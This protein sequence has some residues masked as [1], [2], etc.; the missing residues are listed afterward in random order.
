[1]T[2]FNSVQKARSMI[3]TMSRRGQVVAPTIF[4]PP[5]GGATYYG[6]AYN[7]EQ[8]LHYKD[9]QF[10]AIQAWIREIAGGE[11]LN[12]GRVRKRKDYQTGKAYEVRKAL[13]QKAL[14]GPRASHEFVP[15]DDDDPM[16]CLF[17]RPNE[18]DTPY[19]HWAYTVLFYCLTGAAHWWVMRNA[20]QM[21]VEMWVIP[22]H[23]MKLI[24]RWGG[25][26]L[27]YLVQ[28]PWGASL[29]IPIDEVL[30]FYAHS[31]LNRYEG[32]SQQLA[33]AEWVDAYEASV[34]ARLAQFKNGAI[35][36]FHIALGDT[37]GDPDEAFL[38]RYYSKW[39]ARFQ[40][41]DRTNMPVITGP[42]VEI[43]AL[44][45]NPVDMAYEANESTGRDQTLA[46]YGVPKAIPGMEPP[47]DTSGYAPQRAFT[48]FT[49]NPVC[50]M[51]GERITQFLIRPTPGYEDG[52]GYWDD[53]ILDDPERKLSELT[54]QYDR[55]IITANEFRAAMGHPPY[56]FGGDDPM[57]NG[58]PVNWATGK[59]PAQPQGAEAE[60]TDGA[61]LEGQVRQ[62]LRRDGDELPVVDK[63]EDNEPSPAPL[64]TTEYRYD[65]V[66]NAEGD[67]YA[68]IYAFPSGRQVWRTPPYT[69]ERGPSLAEAH[70]QRWIARRRHLLESKNMDA[71]SGTSGGYV[72]PAER[73]VSVV[74]TKKSLLRV[75]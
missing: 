30:S 63:D 75:K 66:E 57:I 49:I 29:T 70:A 58:A 42:D 4:S 62:A 31:P 9:W 56:R 41:E 13:T 22:T 61:A 1:M 71:S 38:R 60:G 50:K 28:S 11:A 25:G 47:A 34:R 67:H 26:P 17:E 52:I 20:H 2:L 59:K 65:I 40:G 19:D 55:G 18:L 12:L 48:R 43:K 15:F 21:P 46:A 24:T 16:L 14:H 6:Q 3:A 7:W 64:P 23:W 68:E 44:G 35:P 73:V 32:N 69:G 27:G 5:Y 54:Q 10:I 45:I 8:V 72:V 39:F 53:H 37:F 74:A 36:N 33:I 51:F